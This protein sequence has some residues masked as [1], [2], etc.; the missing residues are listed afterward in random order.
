MVTH[1][2]LKHLYS[3]LLSYALQALSIWSIN[4]WA[5][6][7]FNVRKKTWFFLPEWKRPWREQIF[8]STTVCVDAILAKTQRSVGVCPTSNKT[9]PPRHC[10]IKSRHFWAPLNTLLTA[11]SMHTSLLSVP[12]T[13]QACSYWGHCTS[14]LP[15]PRTACSQGVRFASTCHLWLN[16]YITSSE[17]LSQA[18]LLNGTFPS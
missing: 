3:P 10:V 4:N 7:K 12:Q 17:M 9:Q 8:P 2:V 6:L 16:W 14:R 1:E 18:P 13:N 15:L 5:F 11:F